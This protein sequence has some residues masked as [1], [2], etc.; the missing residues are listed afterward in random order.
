MHEP[1]WCLY[2][3]S[4]TPHKV[5]IRDTSRLHGL[6]R[7][8]G[9]GVTSMLHRRAPHPSTLPSSP[10]LQVKLSITHPSSS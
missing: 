4:F 8:S 10:G 6:R 5:H 1:C 7:Y 9:C 3:H 2:A